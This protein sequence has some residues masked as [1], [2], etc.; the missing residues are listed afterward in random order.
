[1]HIIRHGMQRKHPQRRLAPL[2]G[3]AKGCPY[4]F[5]VKSEDSGPEQVTSLLDYVH[6]MLVWLDFLD[7]H[8]NCLSIHTRSKEVHKRFATKRGSE[9]RLT[10]RKA[11]GL[12]R[13][14]VA[15]TSVAQPTRTVRS[16]SI[17][18][19]L[20]IPNSH[21]KIEKILNPGK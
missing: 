15:A 5:F 20:G 13:V 11:R 9:V 8:D 16:E 21:S 1:M 17:G 18:M 6:F 3:P 19:P 7:Y 12:L 2:W 4:A 10:N 14:A